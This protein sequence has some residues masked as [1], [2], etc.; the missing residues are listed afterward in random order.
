LPA[1]S[2]TGGI[3]LKFAK[4]AGRQ[5]KMKM[6]KNLLF[7]PA[8]VVC[9]LACQSSDNTSGKELSSEERQKALKDSS[10]FTTI[11]WLDST[12]RDL[13][14]AKEGAKLEIKYRFKNT[15]KHNLILSDVSPSCGCTTP[16]WPRQ[17]IA[18]GQEEVIKAVFDSK[19][20]IGP[21]HKQ[22]HVMANTLPQNSMTL[23]FSV[24]IT[25]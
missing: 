24:E 2:E 18:P 4:S 1:R 19:D 20:R 7:I 8:V 3:K 6:M 12:Q 15:G 17:P 5:L 16:D 9:L 23:T 13:G 22:I 10:N 25:K 14:T 11:E 21:N